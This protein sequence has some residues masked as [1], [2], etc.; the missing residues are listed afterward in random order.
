MIALHALPCEKQKLLS[1]LIIAINMLQ[2][3]FSTG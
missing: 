1:A 3:W 2:V